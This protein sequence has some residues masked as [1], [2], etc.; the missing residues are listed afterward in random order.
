M[1]EIGSPSVLNPYAFADDH[2]LSTILPYIDSSKIGYRSAMGDL[3]P[4][5]KKVGSPIQTPQVSLP[6]IQI[7]VQAEKQSKQKD[8]YS[9]RWTRRNSGQTSTPGG[10]K[11][12]ALP[13]HSNETTPTSPFR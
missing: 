12:K 9:P 11:T 8:A 5:L 6:K 4:T 2:S 1:F 10:M 3:I 13:D 7:C